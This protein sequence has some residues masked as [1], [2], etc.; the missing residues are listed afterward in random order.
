MDV[1]QILNLIL[2]I[3]GSAAGPLSQAVPG[4]MEQRYRQ[5]IRGDLEDLA[6][7][8]GG[9]GQGKLQELQGQAAG[10][11]AAQEAAQQAALARAG[12]NGAGL[13]GAQLAALRTLQGQTAGA[14][15]GAMS[16]IRSQDLAAAQARREDLN[17]RILNA[18]GQG[19]QTKKNVAGAD[20]G[21]LADSL[22]GVAGLGKTQGTLGAGALTAATSSAGKAAGGAIASGLGALGGA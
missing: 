19:Y 4:P 17:N 13:S 21:N 20:W 5:M 7:G 18:I 11:V 15:R 3:A 14:M 10:Q 12:A 6:N 9:M 16:D 2:S 8:G 1:S 22:K